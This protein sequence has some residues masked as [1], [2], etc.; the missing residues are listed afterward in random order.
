M[1]EWERCLQLLKDPKVSEIESNGPKSFFM[2][3]SG[4]R[5]PIPDISLGSEAAYTDGI[6]KNLVPLLKIGDAPTTAPDFLLE[7]PLETT[8]EG[9]FIKGRC[10]IV[11]PPA[12]NVPQVTI[13]KKAAGLKSLDDIAFGGSMSQEILDF[14]K[15][16]IAANLTI[17]FSGSTGAGKTTFLEACCR[18]IPDHVRIGVAEDTPELVLTQPNA[19]YLHSH[20]WKPGADP[21]RTATLSWVVQQFMRMRID[22]LI[23]GETRGVE[24]GEFLTA[25]NSGVEGSMTTLHASSPTRC[26]DKMTN[27]AMRAAPSAS[28]RTINGDIANAIDVIVQ[29][30]ILPDGRHKVA[31]VEEVTKTLATAENAKISTGTLYSYNPRQDHWT[32][33]GNP[34]DSLR[35]RFQ[36]AQVDMT[37]FVRS[38]PGSTQGPVQPQPFANNPQQPRR[39]LPTG[40]LLGGPR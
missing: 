32:K 38:A 22:R 40:G 3:V 37:P 31:A 39:G 29:L 4:K 21:N 20:P 5:M 12:T 8:F 28:V 16:A 1:N 33:I 25:A 36:Q 2:K 18:L 6:M 15:A 11:F 26:L 27:F 24:F 9:V 10:H 34:T 7:G 13:A 30:D 23:I 35:Q 14:M 19:T 17:A